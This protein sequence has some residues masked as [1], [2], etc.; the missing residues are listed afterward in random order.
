MTLHPASSSRSA[1][2]Y[3]GAA[4]LDRLFRQR[5]LSFSSAF[6]AV[7]VGGA[8][9]LGDFGTA[10]IFF[11]TLPRH[12]VPALRKLCHGVPR[13][14]RAAF[15][16]FL[17][18]TVKPYIAQRFAAWGHVWEDPTARAGSKTRALS[19]A[20]SGGGSPVSVRAGAG[21][22]TIFAADRISSVYQPA[23]RGARSHRGAVRH[24][25]PDRHG[26]LFSVRTAASGRSSYYV[27]AACA[28]TSMML[29][30]LAHERLRQHGHS[31]RSRA[32]RS[33]SSRAAAAA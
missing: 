11:T 28:A 14:G 30:Q 23:L 17:I 16:V 29:V 7:C 22:I 8:R 21:S 12:L 3:V 32:S 31:S 13:G 2:V 5:N 20:A 25:G 33:P 1:Y 24:A 18:L 6:S 9:L 15:A 27:I 10:L 19:A 26:A 4:T